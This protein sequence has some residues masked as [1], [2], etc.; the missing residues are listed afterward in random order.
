MQK[1]KYLYGMRL[2][3]FSLGCQPMTGL[4]E[5]RECKSGQYSRS[6]WNILVY[7]RPLEEWEVR[8]FELDF[9]GTEVIE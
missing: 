4:A 7:N 3:P 2:R 5:W 6:Y 8:N 9:I 1:Q